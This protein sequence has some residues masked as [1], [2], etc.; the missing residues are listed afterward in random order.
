MSEDNKIDMINDPHMEHV[1]K[2]IEK[3]EGRKNQV[4]KDT[5]GHLTTGIG[6]KLP[7]D[8]SLKENDY[9]TNEFVDEKFKETFLT[10]A[11]GAKRLLNG[12]SVPVE[13][14]GILTEMV[15]QMGEQGVSG[16]PSMLKHLKAGNTTEAANEMLRGKG[17]GTASD[18]SK[19][20]PERAIDLYN[21]MVNLKGDSNGIME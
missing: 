9:V 6:Y 12:A 20:T 4:Y 13:A 10:A 5:L 8:S 18:W 19:Q 7:K 3:H 1:K 17:A 11:Q 21:I 2:R 16:F 14:F 15:F